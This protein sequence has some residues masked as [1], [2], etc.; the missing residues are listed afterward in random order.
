MIYCTY[1][2]QFSSL[3]I[4]I[5][6][7]LNMDNIKLESDLERQPDVRSKIMTYI[8]SFCAKRNSCSVC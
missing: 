2:M 8:R 4:S 3:R 6:S 1:N 7:L 5:A